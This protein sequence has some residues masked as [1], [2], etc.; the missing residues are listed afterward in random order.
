MK[1]AQGFLVT[2]PEEDYTLKEISKMTIICRLQEE[3]ISFSGVSS[4]YPEN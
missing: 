3:S 1:G 4:Q 2:I